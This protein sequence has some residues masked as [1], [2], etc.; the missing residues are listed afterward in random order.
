MDYGI[1]YDCRWRVLNKLKMASIHK[2]AYFLPKNKFSNLDYYK[3]DKIKKIISKVG[4]NNKYETS[5]NQTATDMANLCLKNF[6]KNKKKLKEKIDFLIYC[7]QSPDFFLPS[8]SSI[9][10]KETFP[11][12]HIGCIDI[13][14]GCS[15]FVYSLSIAKSLINSKVYSNILIVTADTYSKFINKKDISVASIFGDGCS[16]T[17][18]NSSKD[19]IFNFDQG[20]DGSGYLDLIV[21]GSGLRNLNKEEKTK[22]GNFENNKLFMNGQAMFNFAINEVPKSI[23]NTL[24]NNKIKLTDVDFFI[25]HQAN[26]YMLETI[27]D[28]LKIPS[29]KFYINLKDKGNT[30]S[31]SIPIAINEAI[32]EGKLKK[33][34]RVLLCGFGVG[35]SW[36]SCIIKISNELI[37][38]TLKM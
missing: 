17:L 4:I 34:M 10:Q 18:I 32:K 38:S 6:F 24:K 28:K 9:I 27:R 3:S 14:L 2:I 21:P 5:S 35:Y 22:L 1:Q 7:S 36:S 33:N 15:G 19:Q 13:N 12:N 29:H 31:S 25:L 26:K 30:T 23:M 16:A 20:T 11:N 8:S 37:K